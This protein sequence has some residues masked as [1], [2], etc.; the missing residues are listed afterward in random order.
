M[1][2]EVSEYT[3]NE[4]TDAM[5]KNPELKTPDDVIQFWIA[6]LDGFIHG[7]L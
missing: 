1:M 6:D 4:I 2:I 7:S 5:H 3:M